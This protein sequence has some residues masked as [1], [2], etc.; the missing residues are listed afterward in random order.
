MSRLS[1]DEAPPSDEDPGDS[2]ASLSL[3]RRKVTCFLVLSG[4]AEPS[5]TLSISLKITF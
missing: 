4:A 1:V 2:S 3:G 5:A